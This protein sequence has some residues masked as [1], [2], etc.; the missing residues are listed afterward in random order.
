M[1]A[2]AVFEYVQPVLEHLD[3]GRRLKMCASVVGWLCGHE[4][5]GTLCCSSTLQRGRRR[6][7]RAL[8]ILLDAGLVVRVEDR[9]GTRGGRR[10]CYWLNHAVFEQLL[11]C[12][13]R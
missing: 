1:D 12:R 7:Q 4:G 11:Q 6:V 3:G 8:R 2:I 5:F 10:V 13:G 9:H